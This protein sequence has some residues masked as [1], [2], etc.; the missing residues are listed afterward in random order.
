[1]LQN[2]VV[3]RGLSPFRANAPPAWGPTLRGVGEQCSQRRAGI[4]AFLIVGVEDMRRIGRGRPGRRER[5]R[6][7]GRTFDCGYLACC[8]RTVFFVNSAAR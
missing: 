1:V 7:D 5:T 8:T 4:P 2:V 6:Q 3:E